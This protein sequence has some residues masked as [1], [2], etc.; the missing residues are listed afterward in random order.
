MNTN[1]VDISWSFIL[2]DHFNPNVDISFGVPLIMLMCIKNYELVNKTQTPL[3]YNIPDVV[4]VKLHAI[5]YK[6]GINYYWTSPKSS[7]FRQIRFTLYKK[8]LQK[9]LARSTFFPSVLFLW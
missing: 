5:R 2:M 9:F 3:K 8:K 1:D 7:L 6:P 4:D